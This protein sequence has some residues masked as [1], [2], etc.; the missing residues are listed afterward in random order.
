MA[1]AQ[2]KTKARSNKPNPSTGAA[3][4][5]VVS[6]R[7]LRTNFKAIEAKLAKGVRVQVT[8]R[9]SVI[10]EMQA[11][12]EPETQPGSFADKMADRMARLKELWG[13]TPL[14]VDT[15]A[16]VLEGRNRGIG[17]CRWTALFTS[18]PGRS[19]SN[20]VKA[21]ATGHWMSCTLPQLSRMTPWPSGP[22]TTAREN[23]PRLWA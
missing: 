23:W 3:K 6:V 8:R 1:T 15:T 22:L 16:I 11:P 10:A 20:S 18:E 5:A 14:D 4:V 13:P 12:S 21:F 17:S 9:G 2:A 19:A 7:D